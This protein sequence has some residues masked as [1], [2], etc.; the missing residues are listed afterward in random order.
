MSHRSPTPA[1]ASPPAAGA[2]ERP[3]RVW[4]ASYGSNL[5]RER[6]LTYLCGGRPPGASRTYPG[7]TDCTPPAADVPVRWPGRLH[8]ATRSPV[9]GGGIAFADALGDEDAPTG[10]E[11]L[12]RAYLITAEQFDQVVH[13]ENQ[14]TC[15]TD[16]ACT[17]LLAAVAHGRYACGPGAYET[18]WHIGD[19]AG[20]PVVTFTAPFTA[21]DAARGSHELVRDGR[22][23]RVRACRPTAPYLRMIGRGLA[24]TF[25]LDAG[26]QADYLRAGQ[27]ARDWGREALIGVL[28]GGTS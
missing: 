2:V 4:Y 14:G 6:F 25:G 18:L 9:W 27:G 15:A 17:P 20:V 8:F 11:V 19:R 5:H 23:Q 24:E 1:P 10:T 26:Q 3:T 22:R 7:C 21:A 16:A 12:G 13:F 28:A